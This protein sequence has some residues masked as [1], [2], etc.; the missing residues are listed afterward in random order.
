MVARLA[1]APPEVTHATFVTNG[2]GKKLPVATCEPLVDT[3]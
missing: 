3:V 1:P 2:V